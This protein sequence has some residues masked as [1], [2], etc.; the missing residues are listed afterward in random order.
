VGA[1]ILVTAAVTLLLAAGTASAAGVTDMKQGSGGSAVQGAAGT[2]STTGAEGLERCSQPL[3]AM[4]VVEPQDYVMAALSK[5]SLGSPTSIIRMMIQQSNCF[6]V[7]ERGM[8]MQN[9]MQERALMNSG[10]LRQSSNY[11]GGQ[12]VAADFVLTPNVVFSDN[13]AGGIGGAVGG[14]FGRAGRVVGAVAGGLKFKE[15][16]TSMLVSDARSGVQ[17][18]TAEG[19]AKKA[20]LSLGGVLFGGGAAGALGGYGSTDEGKVIAASLVDN[21]NNVVMVIRNDPSLKRDVGS[22]A[23]EA[24]AGGSTLAGAVFSPGDILRPKINSVKLMADPSDGSAEVTA[25]KKTDELVFLG[26]EADG[27]VRVESGHGGGWV[28]KVLVTN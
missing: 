17:V 2:S 8:G 19:S 5:Y 7:V 1:R 18:A 20:D 4:A 6:I 25:L 27:F 9:M 10:E 24:A 26:E 12:M 28:K 22:L 14:L 21:F 15:A 16:Q 23:Q 11:G 13:D 3:G